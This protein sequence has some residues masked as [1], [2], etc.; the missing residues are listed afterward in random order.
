MSVLDGLGATLDAAVDLEVLDLVEASRVLL[1][2]GVLR[3]PSGPQCVV[4]SS[5]D[6]DVVV[7]L[8]RLCRARGVLQGGQ[9]VVAE[10]ERLGGGQLRE[11]VEGEVPEGEEEVAAEGEEGAEPAAEGDKEGEG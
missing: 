7:L 10:D 3:A 8:R 4:R 9:P 11:E 6:K 5:E 1:L 2:E